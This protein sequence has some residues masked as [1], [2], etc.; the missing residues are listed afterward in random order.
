M[1]RM[2]GAGQRGTSHPEYDMATNATLKVEK[3]R[4]DSEE[5]KQSSD[6]KRKRMK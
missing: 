5:R 4:K 6:G 1:Q 3:Q 2:G